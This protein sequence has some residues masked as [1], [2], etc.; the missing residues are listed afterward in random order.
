VV[1]DDGISSVVENILLLL[2]GEEALQELGVA[3][4]H[5]LRVLRKLSVVVLLRAD[6]AV[7]R[8]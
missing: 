8:N 1:V 6:V 3:L 5:L 7:Y 2:H 4:L